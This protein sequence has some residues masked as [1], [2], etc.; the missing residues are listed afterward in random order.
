MTRRGRRNRWPR[1]IAAVALLSIVAAACVAGGQQPNQVVAATAPSET[2]SAPVTTGPVGVSPDETDLTVDTPTDPARLEQLLVAYARCIEKSFPVVI[3]FRVDPFFGVNTE[4]ASRLE[5]EGDLVTTVVDSCSRR[6]DLDAK[7]G[8]Y[9]TSNPVTPEQE[10][11]AV[12]EFVS[13]AAEISD[14]TAGILSDANLDTIESISDIQDQMYIEAAS[15]EN[16]QD[17]A[18]VGECYLQA[19]FGE[20]RVFS[21]GH[22]WFQPDS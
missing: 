10:R 18:D 15:H 8:A 21:D 4:V 12:A 9:Q 1:G 5:S 14:W 11:K 7:L 16:L 19:L 3:R 22:D 13:C 6:L 2:R 20:P 17:L